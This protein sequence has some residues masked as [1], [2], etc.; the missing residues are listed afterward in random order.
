MAFNSLVFC[1]VCCAFVPFCGAFVTFCAVTFYAVSGI[2]C[3]VCNILCCV[4]SILWCGRE[5]SKKEMDKLRDELRAKA[6]RAFLLLLFFLFSFY[7]EE[8]KHF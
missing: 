8:L 4:C 3:C 6:V 7:L 2:L 5:D 1:G